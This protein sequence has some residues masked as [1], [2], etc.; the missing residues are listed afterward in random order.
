MASIYP[1]ISDIEQRALFSDYRLDPVLND[2]F[3]KKLDENSEELLNISEVNLLT[4]TLLANLGDCIRL[5][6]LKEKQSL[7][8][9]N[10]VYKQISDH[11]INNAFWPVFTKFMS[12]HLSETC[13]TCLSKLEKLTQEVARPDVFIPMALLFEHGVKTP[14]NI[15]KALQYWRQVQ[16]LGLNYG[17]CKIE[18][19]K[20]KHSL[21]LDKEDIARINASK[22]FL[23]TKFQTTC[24]ESLQNP[25]KGTLY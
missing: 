5:S 3:C 12:G 14:I 16:D 21:K 4:N 9:L 1:N 10:S 6:F 25:W 15:E 24:G 20:N 11:V 19:I 23:S 18:F 17:G 2:N 8:H 22:E 13:T 7:N